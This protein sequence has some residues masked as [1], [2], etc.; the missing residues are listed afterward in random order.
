MGLSDILNSHFS[1]IEHH[2]I[3][4]VYE[5]ISGR[6]GAEPGAEDATMRPYI[7]HFRKSRLIARVA[8]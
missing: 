4:T 8:A 1:H 3:C 6:A 7:L 5:Y 2:P